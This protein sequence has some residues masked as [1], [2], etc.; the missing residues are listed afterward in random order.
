MKAKHLI[1]PESMQAMI[2]AARKLHKAGKPVY[3]TSLLK[4][5]YG[6]NHRSSS[7][8]RRLVA[9]E[10]DRLNIPRA[11]RV[12]KPV[13]FEQITLNVS[14]VEFKAAFETE[15][16]QDSIPGVLGGM[17]QD[18]SDVIDVSLPDDVQ[19]RCDE[20]AIRLERI[21]EIDRE[22]SKMA[23][24]GNYAALS[25]LMHRLRTR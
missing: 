25:L 22:L 16:L 24:D 18:D 19:E 2:S 17:S 11:R 15:T 12:D 8:R 7:Q 21:R 9:A 13:T 6:G 4:H 23:D 14:P 10:L 20:Y 1:R 5:Y 3:V